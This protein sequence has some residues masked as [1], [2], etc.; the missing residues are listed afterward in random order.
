MAQDRTQV[1]KARDMGATALVQ[2]APVRL[3]SVPLTRVANRIDSQ[4]RVPLV[5][6]VSRERVRVDA[7]SHKSRLERATGMRSV[8]ESTSQLPAPRSRAILLTWT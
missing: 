3:A 5:L 2:E 4:S 7:H 1:G 8:S 6:S